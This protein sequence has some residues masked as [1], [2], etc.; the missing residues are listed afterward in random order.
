ME[1]MEAY[2]KHPVRLA[3][4]WINHELKDYQP[5]HVLIFAVGASFGMTYLYNQVFHRVSNVIIHS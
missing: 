1:L 2:I 3:F 5:A 4:S